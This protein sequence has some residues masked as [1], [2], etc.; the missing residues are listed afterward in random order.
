V[1][2]ARY[3]L[4]PYIKQMGFVFKRVKHVSPYHDSSPCATY[5][6]IN[7]HSYYGPLTNIVPSSKPASVFLLSL[8]FTATYRLVQLHSDYQ[9]FQRPMR[10]NL[11]IGPLH[12]ALIPLP[13]PHAIQC[14]DTPTRNIYYPVFPFTFP[15]LNIS[16]SPHLLVSHC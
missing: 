16:S 3:A 14:T 7:K 6:K 1:F 15:S 9:L 12:G 13:E 11:L 4:S 8:S 5:I 2:T 10:I